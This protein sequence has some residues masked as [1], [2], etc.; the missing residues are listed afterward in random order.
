M[1][2]YALLQKDASWYWSPACDIAYKTLQAAITSNSALAHYNS[3][4]SLVL[5]CDAS[6]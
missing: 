4:L 6:S 2:L 1:P 3:A 5:E